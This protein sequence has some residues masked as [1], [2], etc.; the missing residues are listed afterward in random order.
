MM[1][2]RRGWFGRLAGDWFLEGFGAEDEDGDLA[3]WNLRN[4]ACKMDAVR[5]GA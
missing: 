3:S 2:M 4:V 5:V 1:C